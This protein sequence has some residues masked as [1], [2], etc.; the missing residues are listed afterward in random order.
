MTTSVP[1]SCTYVQCQTIASSG[2]AVQLPVCSNEV[3]RS[4]DQDSLI[5]R[6]VAEHGDRTAVVAV[7]PGALLTPWAAEGIAPGGTR[8]RGAAAVL[9]PFMPGQGYGL[10]I[11]SILFGDRNPAARLPVT[12]PARRV[13]RNQILIS[14]FPY[15][16]L[17]I[18]ACQDGPY[19]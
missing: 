5:A 2:G 12:F 8:P 4:V 13:T 7:T 17:I 10:A 19:V 18:H 11:A 15:D 1:F 3:L 9:I 14:R 6:V 16:E